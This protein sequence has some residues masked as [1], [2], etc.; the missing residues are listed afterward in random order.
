MKDHSKFAYSGDGSCCIAIADLQPAPPP[1]PSIFEGTMYEQLSKDWL[2]SCLWNNEI[3]Q[4]MF[5]FLAFGMTTVDMI[6]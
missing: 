2:D 5:D 4:N 6:S 1:I 3:D